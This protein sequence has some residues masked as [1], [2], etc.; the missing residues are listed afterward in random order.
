[1]GVVKEGL[2]L[3]SGRLKKD[4]TAQMGRTKLHLLK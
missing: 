4:S 3:V 2:L 1:M